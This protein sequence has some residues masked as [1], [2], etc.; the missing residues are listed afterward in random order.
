[1]ETKQ[2][3]LIDKAEYQN[4]RSGERIVEYFNAV[5]FHNATEARVLLSKMVKEH[6]PDELISGLKSKISD[7][8]NFVE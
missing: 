8:E 6:Y 1:M 7:F 4:G 3:D 5:D 2:E